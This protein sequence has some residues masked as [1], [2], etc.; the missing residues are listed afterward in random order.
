MSLSNMT[1]KERYKNNQALRIALRKVAELLGKEWSPCL[2]CDV[3]DC[4]W[5][6]LEPREPEIVN[7]K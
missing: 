2:E 6:A 1:E 5:C 3:F 4:T 7:M